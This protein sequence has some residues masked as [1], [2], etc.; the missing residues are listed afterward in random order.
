MF[1]HRYAVWW[2]LTWIL[3]TLSSV[4]MMSAITF[5]LFGGITPIAFVLIQ[6]L[7]G[8]FGLLMTALVS[9]S[10]KDERIEG[11]REV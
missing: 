4:S 1:K 10:A 11:L 3:T 2:P 8:L 6:G 9:V 7:S 5:L